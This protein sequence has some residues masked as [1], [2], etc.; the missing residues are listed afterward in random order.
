MHVQLLF[1]ALEPPANV[2]N[3]FIRLCNN[4]DDMHS[5][6]SFGAFG[7]MPSP[8]FCASAN[9]E[10]DC[11][12]SRNHLSLCGIVVAD[13]VSTSTPFSGPI[14]SRLPAGQRRCITWAEM[15]ARSYMFGAVR[16]APDKF[17]AA[18]LKELRARPD[19]FLVLTRSDTD[20]GKKTES[21]GEFGGDVVAQ[22]RMRTFE[23]PFAS[24]QNRP[25][26]RGAWNVM[27]SA[28]DVLYGTNPELLGYLTQLERP[29]SAGWFFHFKNFPVK[30][31]VI[32]DRTPNR[33]VHDLVTQVA[34]AALCAQG[35]AEGDFTKRKYYKAS[36]I[37]FQK[38]ASER[39]AWMPAGLGDWHT[40]SMDE[41]SDSDVP[42]LD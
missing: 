21:F 19:L 20:P 31:F 9:P 33:H 2:E 41:G 42:S 8:S 38:H 30:Y 15:E 25:E 1:K 10:E 5:F 39:L 22:L 24:V 37:L 32:L 29:R 17:T 11:R 35:L 36:D 14:P 27:R 28:V 13:L 3:R 12:A 18:F 4:F 34:W 23:A 7:M 16:N 6:L 40:T 26:G